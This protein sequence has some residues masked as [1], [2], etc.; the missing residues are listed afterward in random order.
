MPYKVYKIHNDRRNTT[1]G[2]VIP[3]GGWYHIVEMTFENYDQLTHVG[4]FPGY[5]VDY[6]EGIVGMYDPDGN[7]VDPASLEIDKI[8]KQVIDYTKITETSNDLEIVDGTLSVTKKETPVKSRMVDTERDALIAQC[9]RRG[10]NIDKRWSTQR[11]KDAMQE[12]GRFRESSLV[13]G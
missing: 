5:S 12:A 2:F 11:I 6:V 10:V 7:Q 8:S 9:E 3:N 1:C 4:Q 13:A